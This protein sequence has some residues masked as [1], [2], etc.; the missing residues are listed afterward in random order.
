MVRKAVRTYS[1]IEKGFQALESKDAAIRAYYEPL[2]YQASEQLLTTGR[3]STSKHRYADQLDWADDITTLISIDDPVQTENLRRSRA[4]AA[5]AVVNRSSLNRSTAGTTKRVPSTMRPLSAPPKMS[6]SSGGGSA[7]QA[8]LQGALE[9]ATQHPASSQA[10]SSQGFESRLIDEFL[11]SNSLLPAEHQQKQHQQ[12]RMASQSQK[13]EPVEGSIPTASLPLIQEGF[14]DVE[15]GLDGEDSCLLSSDAMLLYYGHTS[16]HRRHSA[17]SPSRARSISPAQRSPSPCEDRTLSPGSYSAVRTRSPAGFTGRSSIPGAGRSR[18]SPAERPHSAAPALR[19]TSAH[20]PRQQQQ[21]QGLRQLPM[22][23]TSASQLPRSMASTSSIGVR[24]SSSDR[25]GTAATPNT[26]TATSTST[27]PLAPHLIASSLVDPI[28]IMKSS[29]QCQQ[30][31][32]SSSRA[33]VSSSSFNGARA[34]EE[35]SRAATSLRRPTSAGPACSSWSSPQAGPGLLSHSTSQFQPEKGLSRLSSNHL[36]LGLNHL[37]VRDKGPSNGIIWRD[38]SGY[39]VVTSKARRPSSAQAEFSQVQQKQKQPVL[40]SRSFSLDGAEH[41]L[42]DQQHNSAAVV[43]TSGRAHHLTKGTMSSSSQQTR[44]VENNSD[45]SQPQLSSLSRTVQQP[46][47]DDAG[48]SQTSVDAIYSSADPAANKKPSNVLSVQHQERFASAPLPL[49]STLSKPPRTPK[50]MEGI[51]PHSASSTSRQQPPSHAFAIDRSGSSGSL[52]GGN[53][54]RSGSL[55]GGNVGGPSTS[56]A[57]QPDCQTRYNSTDH[58]KQHGEERVEWPMI[59]PAA[60]LLSRRN[61][62]LEEARDSALSF[63]SKH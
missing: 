12:Q 4:R 61:R 38:P 53:V 7:L 35:K 3:L 42:E 10:L 25:L 44:E 17:S 22:R 39:S 63:L 57:S 26:N 6:S 49:A 19:P 30:Q 45:D 55:I 62:A 36:L 8:A 59:T 54:E 46:S 9:A 47:C 31:R 50:S 48:P 13:L 52:I 15:E 56:S 43:K 60:V 37:N 27:A 1:A 21:Q 28:L 11:K 34:D 33:H 2:S 18:V 20:S 40:S 23:P 51:R 29:P 41:L 14:E 24:G 5:S 16:P 32:Q 58:H